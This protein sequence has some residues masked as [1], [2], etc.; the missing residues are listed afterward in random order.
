MINKIL[1]L[2]ETVLFSQ[3]HSFPDIRFILYKINCMHYLHSKSLYHFGTN[4]ILIDQYNRILLNRDV[5]VYWNIY[6]WYFYCL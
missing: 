3:I 5:V 1:K 2:S 4:E 6:I